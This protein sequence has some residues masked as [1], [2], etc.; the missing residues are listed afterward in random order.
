M[1]S[2]V[3]QDKIVTKLWLF[4]LFSNFEESGDGDGSFEEE[5]MMRNKFSLPMEKNF[6]H[7]LQGLINLTCFTIM[8]GCVFQEIIRYP[9]PSFLYL[10]P[11]YTAERQKRKIIVIDMDA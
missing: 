3:N 10:T 8:D 6:S 7:L 1:L 4:A 11:M 2:Q 9:S 5:T